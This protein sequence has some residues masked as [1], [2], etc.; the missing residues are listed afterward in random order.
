M[1]EQVGGTAVLA[2]AI[3]TI[4]GRAIAAGSQGLEPAEG[5]TLSS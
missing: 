2:G 5:E 4:D 3:A 1:I